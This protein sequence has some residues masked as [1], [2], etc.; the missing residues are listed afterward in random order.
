MHLRRR[1]FRSNWP[2]TNA[3]SL[4]VAALLAAVS[5]ATSASAQTP[6]IASVT[7]S[8]TTIAG[9]SGE[10]ATG[11][12]TLGAPAPAGGVVV[13]LASSNIEL[14]ATMPSVR[15]PAGAT[16][17]TFTVATNARYRQYSGLAFSAAISAT[18]QGSTRSATLSTTAQPRPPDFTSGSQ[19]QA[20]TQWDGLM[21]GGVAPIGGYEGILYQCS[22][23][24]GNGFG[25]CTFREECSNGCRR[26]PP[27]GRTFSDFCATSGPNSVSLSRNYIV[28]GDRVAASIV[29]EAPAGQAQDQEQAVPGIIDTGF[30]A[31]HFPISSFGF[32]DGATSVPF[33]VATS[34]VPTIQFVDV[35]GHWFNASIPPFLI[36][37]GRAGHRW[38]V[39]VPPDPPPAVAIPTLGDFTMTGLNPVTGGERTFGSVDLSG[40]SRVGGPTLTLTSSHPA[41]VPSTTVE[42]PANEN[43]LGFQL[44]FDTAPPAADTDVTVTVSDGRY[45]FSDVLTVRT[46][47]PPPVLAGVSVNPTSVVGGNSATGTVTL[48]AP[49][50]GS[51][52]V[53]LSTPAPASVATMPTSVTVPAGATSRTFTITTS[54]VTSQFNMNIFAD[55]PGSP[56]QQALLLITPGGAT[57]IKALTINPVDLTGGASATGTVTLTGSAPAGGAVVTLSKALSNGAA[58]TVPVTIPA[59]VTVPAGQTTASF[60]IGTS[61]VTAATNVRIS[62]TY[63]GTTANA[64]MTLFPLLGQLLFEGNVPGG[65][66]AV[67]TVR[68]NGAAPAGGAVVALS[69]A[70]PS[71]ATVPANVTVPAGQTTATFTANTAPVT[72]TTAVAISASLAGTTLTGNL[73]LVVSRAV[74]S[75]TLTPSSLVGPGSVTGRVTL[76]SAAPSGN[77]NVALASSNTVLATV[78]FSVVVPAGQT[79]ATF[80]VNAA[81]VTTTSTVAISATFENVTQ[82]ATLTITPSGSSAASLSAVSLNPTSVVGGNTSTGTVTLTAAAPAGGAVVSLS[83]NSSAAS[84]PASVT[85]AAGS[86]SATFTIA[87]STVT[88]TATATVSAVYA[89][90]TRT[91]ALTVN[92]SG[93]TTPSAPS[94]VAPA[95]GATNVAQPVTLDWNNV[96]DATSYEVQVDNSST[97]ASPF[98]ATQT[99]TASQAALSGLPAQQLWWR[100]RARNAAGVSGPFSSVRSFTP[101]AA[102]TGPTA[103]L[104]VTAT[105]RSGERITSSPVG[106]NVP[107]GSTGSA[108]FNT[109]TSITLSVSNGRDAIWS[110]ACSSG[111]NKTRTCTFTVNA[112]ASVTANVQ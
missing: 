81:Q 30:N 101:Q 84:T 3:G 52:V 97:I 25:T 60:T 43:L 64:D 36:T 46:P 80:T 70:N 87:T 39:M 23:A 51:T 73:F 90:V 66:P 29:A 68:L 38:L 5:V 103:T 79:S 110:G 71:L 85:V 91:A 65:T 98:V 99:V 53:A 55:L 62:G 44:F 78:P 58:G 72:Q 95:N 10:S 22:P 17:A 54:P 28:S 14:A 50:S 31:S 86:T 42:T 34:Y 24:T 7:L 83:D 8:P 35:I 108:V 37:N 1:R 21:C 93:S 94:L 20:N 88:A 74:S 107:V 104:S 67:G 61:A 27:N 109:G 59:S 89:G 33:E 82:S 56:G 40:L 49:Q 105:G 75:V 48:S 26:V 11:T 96:T 12:V 45:H 16:S 6:T 57:T 92:A 102:P 18:L 19:A 76:R 112:N 106:I 15:V 77:A 111:G 4:M 63:S 32:P 47:A 41:I 2:F 69:S 9:G 100:V 13:T